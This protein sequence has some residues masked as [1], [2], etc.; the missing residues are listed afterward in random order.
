MNGLR[1]FRFPAV[2]TLLQES[3]IESIFT[4]KVR[5]VP[6]AGTAGDEN[7]RTLH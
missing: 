5:A 7:H 3:G 4:V 6:F 1:K 2:R